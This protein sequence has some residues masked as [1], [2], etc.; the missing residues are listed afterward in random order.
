MVTHNEY[1]TIQGDLG[2]F[3][4]FQ[5]GYK[6]QT[7]LELQTDR[8]QDGQEALQNNEFWLPHGNVFYQTYKGLGWGFTDQA[9]NLTLKPKNI[10]AALVQL[11]STG[12]FRPKRSES[13]HAIEHKSTQRFSYA[14]LDLTDENN[15]WSYFLVTRDL[16]GE[17]EEAARA[18][19]FNSDN[20]DYLLAKGL[21]PRVRLPDPEYLKKV[22]SGTE[23]DAKDPIW[24]ASRL[25]SFYYGSCFLAGSHYVN[26]SVLR[27]VRRRASASEQGRRRKK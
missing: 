14:K 21:H 15:E 8:C 4:R 16:S 5:A 6:W 24:R 18:I 9:R 12:I 27:G 23:K 1:T 10:E 11:P 20:V 22:F 7:A 26:L 25:G 13:W 19:G 3:R 2:A 17:R